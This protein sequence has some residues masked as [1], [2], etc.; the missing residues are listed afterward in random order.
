[1]GNISPHFPLGETQGDAR[2]MF[3]KKCGAFPFCGDPPLFLLNGLSKT[4]LKKY[5]KSKS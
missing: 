3:P 2:G 4:Q 1:V 5:K